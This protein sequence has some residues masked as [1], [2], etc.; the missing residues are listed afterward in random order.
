MKGEHR[1][2]LSAIQLVCR[3]TR[4]GGVATRGSGERER[5][6][7]RA[8]KQLP[9]CAKINSRPKPAMR[10]APINLGTSDCPPAMRG[11][12][13]AA[14]HAPAPRGLGA[15]SPPK[16]RAFGVSFSGV[17]ADSPRFLVF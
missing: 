14:G 4:K 6:S 17:L 2:Q 1:A 12:R 15:A 11:S 13:S 7:A 5:E 8:G 3:G 16:P 10:E 9:R